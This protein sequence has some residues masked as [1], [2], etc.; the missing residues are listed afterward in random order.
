MGAGRGDPEPVRTRAGLGTLEPRGEEGG[1]G[2]GDQAV[3]EGKP[4]HL[5]GGVEG[6]VQRPAPRV[7][8]GGSLETETEA[9][10]SGKVTVERGTRGTLVLP[11]GIW[12]Q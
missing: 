5:A 6:T 11:R 4:A 2:V 8:E 1:A 3:R 10:F 9:F 12:S 7:A